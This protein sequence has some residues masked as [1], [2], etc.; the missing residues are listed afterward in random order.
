[1]PD[2]EFDLGAWI[3]GSGSGTWDIGRDINGDWAIQADF[4]TWSGGMTGFRTYLDLSGR[5]SPYYVV[6]WTNYDAGQ[7]LWYE[8]Q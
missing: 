8:K 5:E 3:C 4:E 1:M 2:Y 6:I 7:A